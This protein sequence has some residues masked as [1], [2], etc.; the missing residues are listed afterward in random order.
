MPFIS[1]TIVRAEQVRFVAYKRHR[2]EDWIA[3]NNPFWLCCI[4]IVHQKLKHTESQGGSDEKKRPST[5]FLN[6]KGAVSRYKQLK[7]KAMAAPSS[8]VT[9]PA[10]KL[11]TARIEEEVMLAVSLVQVR[12]DQ[13]AGDHGSMGLG[14]GWGG[15]LD[16]SQQAP[17]SGILHATNQI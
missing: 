11:P 3:T 12:A 5:S 8:R 13:L 17:E 4:Q 7:L 6:G 10:S 2:G 15:S 16:S 9:S 1:D 14:A